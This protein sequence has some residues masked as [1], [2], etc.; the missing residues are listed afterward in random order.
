MY[1]VKCGVELADSERKC[2][3]CHTPVYMPGIDEDPERPYPK[4]EKPEPVNPR[5]IYFII[6]FVCL[7]SAIISF[8][9]DINLNF[10]SVTWSGYV[11][12]AVALAYTVV[13]L[14]GW[15]KK[16]NPAIFV[17]VNF[18][19]AALY[20]LYI[21]LATGGDWFLTFALPITAMAALIISSI[22]ILSYY[23][24]RGYLYI[25]GGAFIAA[26]FASPVIE[27]LSNVT[28]GLYDHLRWSYYPFIALALI[29]I[30]LIVIA[31]V[32]PLRESLCRIFAV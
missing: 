13:I 26:A 21:C 24:K 31:I 4:F 3:L 15:F 1:C 14:P 20:L 19:A 12:G 5:G 16:Y 28:F 18:A 32:K 8:V 10:G 2:P 9:C 17:P 25:W 22:T 27:L 6:S 29:G 11:L 30:M 7:I 23:I